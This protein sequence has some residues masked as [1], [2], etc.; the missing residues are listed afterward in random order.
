MDRL[1]VHLLGTL[2]VRRSG[3]PIR[4]PSG[5]LRALL[6]ALAVRTGRPVSPE[7]IIAR[8]WDDRPPPA[9]RA[10]VRGHVK[11]LRRL[12]DAGAGGSFVHS[13]PGGYIL[14]IAPSDLD[15]CRFTELAGQAGAVDDLDTRRDLLDRALAIWR[16][17]AL[18]DV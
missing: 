13:T 5:R 1:S 6:A 2:D 12:L 17:P 10:T 11:R 15:V 14:A 4:L 9:A 16:G 3:A 18:A 8:L 7:E